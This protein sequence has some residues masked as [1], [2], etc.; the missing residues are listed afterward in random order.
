MQ[1]YFV[2][3]AGLSI[4]V[5]ILTLQKIVYAV[6]YLLCPLPHKQADALRL[7]EE[8]L[9]M[10]LAYT[11]TRELVEESEVH[12]AHEALEKAIDT[13]KALELAEQE[14]RQDIAEAERLLQENMPSS[15]SSSSISQGNGNTNKQRQSVVL[16]ISH[17]VENYVESRLAEA[18]LAEEQAR[19][20]EMVAREHLEE[21]QK[22][23]A[24]LKA[25]LDELKLFKLRE[26][27]GL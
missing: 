7:A 13:E 23:E 26:E 16:D 15:S 18:Q 9:E 17:R 6:F 3:T 1:T 27:R 14:A 4:K 20:A 10:A 19:R 25:T 12:S 5:S 2:A 11:H 21:L 22:R 8:V 24:D